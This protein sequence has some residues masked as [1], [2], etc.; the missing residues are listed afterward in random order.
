M[1]YLADDLAIGDMEQTVAALKRSLA[2][3]QGGDQEEYE[4]LFQSVVKLQREIRA[5]REALKPIM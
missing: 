5:R 3:A 2:E 4:L 1:A